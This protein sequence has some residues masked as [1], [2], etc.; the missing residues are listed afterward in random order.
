MISLIIDFSPRCSLLTVKA[1]LDEKPDDKNVKTVVDRLGKKLEAAYA[2]EK[3]AEVSFG[4]VHSSVSS[5]CL[6]CL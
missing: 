4:A 6:A 3:K 1:L 5:S 2:K